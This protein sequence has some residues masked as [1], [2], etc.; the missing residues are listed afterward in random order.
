M[1]LIRVGQDGLKCAQTVGEFAMRNLHVL[2]FI[3]ERL[4]FAMI[5]TL[6]FSRTEQAV[7]WNH[8]SCRW[9]VEVRLVHLRNTLWVPVDAFF[10]QEEAIATT[11]AQS[12]PE[13]YVYG[14]FSA[15]VICMTKEKLT[16]LVAK[17]PR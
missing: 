2:A 15:I 12:L 14:P 4:P 17:D 8:L 7:V 9:W 1:D 13:S 3:Y 11:L 6:P 5:T 10:V 16:V